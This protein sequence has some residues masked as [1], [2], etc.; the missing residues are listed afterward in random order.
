MRESIVRLALPAMAT[1]FEFVLAGGDPV[2]LR[3]VGEQAM[4][5]IAECEAAISPFLRGSMIARVNAQAHLRPVRTDPIT[6]GLL[7]ACQELH[8][9]SGGAFDPTVG[10]L[11][12]ALG[13]RGAPP[14]DAAGVRRARALVGMQHVD[15]DARAQTVRF[16]RSGMALDLGAIG[17]G[18]ALDL[19]GEVL[20]Q[21]GVQC[22]LLHGGTSSVLALGAPPGQSGWRIGIGPRSP[23][24]VATLCDAGLSVSAGRGRQARQ[25]DGTL[26]AHVLDPRTGLPATSTAELTAV[27]TTTALVAD[28]WSTALLVDPDL[29]PPADSGCLLAVATAGDRHWARTGARAACFALDAAVPS[30]TATPP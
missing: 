25:A 22:A 27:V 24:P 19:A 2:R 28:A 16:A 1:R 15:L 7:A 20:R 11:L 23:Q 4:Q 8:T 17:K 10:P 13:F 3:A 9:R 26:A 6:F 18:H 5:A 14:A 30:A 29:V 12:R 21:H